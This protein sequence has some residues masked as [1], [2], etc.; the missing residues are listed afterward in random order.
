M[1]QF[2]RFAYAMNNPVRYKDP[3]GRCPCVGFI[4]GGVVDIVAQKIV[5]RHADINWRSVGVSAVAGAITGGIAA[6]AR[7]AAIRGN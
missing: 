4:V 6:V 7:A 1:E 5:N 2:N 3:D